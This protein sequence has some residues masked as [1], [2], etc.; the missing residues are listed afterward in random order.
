MYVIFVSSRGSGRQGGDR[1]QVRPGDTIN[2]TVPC[3]LVMGLLSQGAILQMQIGP[4]PLRPELARPTSRP[5]DSGRSSRPD[6]ARS[7]YSTSRP[8]S[9]RS[10]RPSRPAR[11]ASRC[12]NMNN[13]RPISPFTDWSPLGEMPTR[14]DVDETE[15]ISINE[16]ESDSDYVPHS[17]LYEPG[18][19]RPEPIEDHPA[20]KAPEGSQT[21]CSR[22]NEISA[23]RELSRDNEISAKRE[24]S[25][26][27]DIPNNL[28]S[29]RGEPSRGSRT[30]FSNIFTDSREGLQIASL[31]GLELQEEEGAS[32]FN[33]LPPSLGVLDKGN[34][35]W[36]DLGPC[37]L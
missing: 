5:D 7:L 1:Q 31:Q 10:L 4:V 12:P 6:S 2:I 32:L 14:L 27:N 37:E 29:D 3:D 21:E 26:D 20:D 36:E 15:I 35:S 11:P 17:P 22:D 34:T 19:P 16:I 13:E 28:N 24:P 8:D 33:E 30:I 25:R 23:R 18:S 9:G